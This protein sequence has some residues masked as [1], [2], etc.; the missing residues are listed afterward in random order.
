M[1]L[2]AGI[3]KQSGIR[4]Q[5]MNRMG[6]LKVM[7]CSES[8]SEIFPNPSG[9]A[10]IHM[11]GATT[12]K[13]S[14]RAARVRKNINFSKSNSEHATSWRSSMRSYSGFK[15]EIDPPMCALEPFYGS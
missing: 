6:P 14:D 13:K 4:G 1:T 2:K 3:M 9:P 7:V 11:A 10:A 12:T 8:D 15:S 5:N